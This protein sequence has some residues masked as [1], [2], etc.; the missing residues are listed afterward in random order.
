MRSWSRHEQQSIRMALATVPHHS[1]GRVHTEYGALR[2]QNI[3]TRAR[4]EE[5]ETSTAPRRQ[6][7]PQHPGKQYYDLGDESV[8]G[9]RPDRLVD[10]RPQ[11]RVQRHTV[12]QMGDVVPV[13]PVLIA[14][15]PLL[16]CSEVGSALGR[17]EPL[18]PHARVRPV[19]EQ[20]AGL[21]RDLAR[22]GQARHS[23]AM[24]VMSWCATL[25]RGV[26]L[27]SDERYSLLLLMPDYGW[28]SAASPGRYTNTG[29]RAEVNSRSRSSPQRHRWLTS[30][31]SCS[32]S[33]SSS[34]RTRTRRSL[35]SSSSSE[36]WIF[37]LSRR[38]GCPQCKL[39]S[40]T[41][42]FHR[43]SSWEGC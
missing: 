4:A 32:L 10:V 39:C 38:G 13:L 15:L 40:D 8:P 31:R 41:S 24:E 25:V 5:R 16:G 12:E 37:Q 11:E 27:T 29:C 43:C 2:S 20:A 1:Y 36:R 34:S 33:S 18:P 28:R 30:L 3:A 21:R 19:L 17:W 35:R 7:T 14:P 6:E 23:T 26:A 22:L 42:R 9:T